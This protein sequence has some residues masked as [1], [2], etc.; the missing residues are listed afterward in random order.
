[1]NKFWETGR[2]IVAVGRNY[3]QHAKELGN[4]VPSEPF[5]FLKPTSSYL[6]QG[7]GPI[8]IP[9]ES[10]DIHHEV[11]LGVVISK[12]G[13]DIDL[14]SAMDYV[15]GYTLA[16]DMT[17]RDQQ[18]IAKAKSLPWTVSKGYD[19]FCPISG[20]IP[21]DEI[22]DLN[23]VELWCSV[24]GQ[25]KQK[26]NTNQ[27]IFDIPHLIQY[28]STIMTLESGDLILTGTPSGVGPVKPGQVIKCGITGLNGDMQ[29]DI[30]LRK[31]N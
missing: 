10:S 21:K 8:E 16:L 25:I 12:K 26:G 14:K 28:I 31:R 27:M 18:A 15:S 22:K 13:R 11:E 7:T 23:N 19:T 24:D 30:V 1:M 2:K 9:S 3:A 6:L 5:F 29:F 4:E 17:S 20:F